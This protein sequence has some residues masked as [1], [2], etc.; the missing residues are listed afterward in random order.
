MSCQVASA[1]S[2]K[3]SGVRLC[4]LKC[5]QQTMTLA[6]DVMNVMLCFF[7]YFLLILIV[8]IFLTKGNEL[9]DLAMS[10]D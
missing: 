8:D 2:N 9:C 10:V 4:W 5:V 1:A 7:Y 6:H 3:L